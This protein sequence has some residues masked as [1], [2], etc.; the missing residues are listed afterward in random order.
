MS[1]Y[2]NQWFASSGAGSFYS[3]QIEQSL[4]FDANNSGTSQDP[5]IELTYAATT[6]TSNATF[7]GTNF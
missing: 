1:S 6:V 2:G 4:R 5:K 3:H 7:F